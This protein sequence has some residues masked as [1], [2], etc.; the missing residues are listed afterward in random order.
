MSDNTPTRKFYKTTVTVTVLSED[1]PVKFDD[2]QELHYEITNGSCV[3]SYD[4]ASVEITAQEAVTGLNELGS[5]PGFFQLDENGNTLDTDYVD[6]DDDFDDDEME[7]EIYTNHYACPDDGVMWDSDGDS[8]HNDE[9]PEC[10][11]EITP[12]ASTEIATGKMESH[13]GNV[14]QFLEIHH[15]KFPNRYDALEPGDQFK[16]VANGNLYTKKSDSEY[17]DE[18]GQ[19]YIEHPSQK[20]IVVKS[21]RQD[22]NNRR[23]EKNGLFPQHSDEVN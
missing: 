4:E 1:Q 19:L 6:E 5:E 2:L 14:E 7:E 16:F 20:I 13:V 3:G 21:Q 10:G 8:M 18:K 11:S 9:C 15:A 22:E 17:T 23:D 12:Y